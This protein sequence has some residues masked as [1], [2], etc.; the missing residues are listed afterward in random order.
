ML[1]REMRT[2]VR[3]LQLQRLQMLLRRRKRQRHQHLSR[4]IHLS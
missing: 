2:Q 4:M 3:K 1:Q